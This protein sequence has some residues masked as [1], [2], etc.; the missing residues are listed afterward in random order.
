MEGGHNLNNPELVTYMIQ[1]SAG[2][3]EWLKAQ[4]MN[5]VIGETYGSY[6]VDGEA[7]GLILSL[8]GRYE[9]LGG[10][11]MYGVRGTDIIMDNGRAAGVIGVDKFG[12]KVT[13]RARAVILAS[14]GFGGDLELCARLDP[15]LEG[16]V[17]DNS[18]GAT[19]DGIK[20][21]EAIGAATV[22]MEQIQSHPT[23]HQ[24]SSTM[25]TEGIRGSGGI[26]LNTAGKRFTNENTYRDVV[27]A[28]ILGQD[29]GKACL[30]F[31]KDLMDHNANVQGYYAQGLITPYNT[32]DDVA[33]Y[34]N[35]DPA[36]LRQTVDTWNSYVAGKNDPEFN[37]GF[38]WIRDLSQGPYFALWVAPGIHHTMGGV[39][40][41]VR[42]EV[43]STDGAVIPGLFASGEVTGGIHG[44][45]RVGGNAILDILLYGRVSGENAAAYIQ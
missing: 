21:A 45:N 20:M 39:K 9:S 31:N 23:I 2:V 16:F 32:L 15:K 10:T 28:A 7:K 1:N 22:D 19:G 13:I 17:T 38:S 24:A 34:M 40:I 42:T 3:V 18:P 33:G 43:I 14:G 5:P 26:L 35:V 12:G 44:G 8:L 27:S 36:V 37:S 25:L 30:L 6:S 41:N 29:Q 4:G 11:V